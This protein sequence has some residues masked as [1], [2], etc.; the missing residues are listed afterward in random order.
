MSDNKENKGQQD[1]IRV[2]ATDPNEVEFLHRQ[3]PHKSHQQ[4]KEAIR[5]FGPL[6]AAIV[7]ALEGK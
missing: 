6:R 2:D 5:R 1:R 4:I 7:K 3:Y